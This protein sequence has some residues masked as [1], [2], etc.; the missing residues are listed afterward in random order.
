M[1]LA[2]TRPELLQALALQQPRPPM[3]MQPFGTSA[4]LLNPAALMQ[5]PSNALMF[6]MQS[7]AQ[8]QQNQARLLEEQKRQQQEQRERQQ[9][10]HLQQMQNQQILMAMGM[11]QPNFYIFY[12]F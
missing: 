8:A 10:D 1:A 5:N 7:A 11:F 2:A 3:M 12:H 6:Q 4:G 9:R